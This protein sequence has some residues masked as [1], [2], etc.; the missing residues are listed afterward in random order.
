MTAGKTTM[1]ATACTKNTVD[2]IVHLDVYIHIKAR[3]RAKHNM[4]KN[5]NNTG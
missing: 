4:N 3:V 5:E 2:C 1:S